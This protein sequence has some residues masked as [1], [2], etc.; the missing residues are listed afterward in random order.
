MACN[1]ILSAV[2]LNYIF[3]RHFLSSQFIVT[4][5]SSS[6]EG[7]SNITELHIVLERML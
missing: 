2:E 4:V 6:L 1:P 7:S 5:S 3:T